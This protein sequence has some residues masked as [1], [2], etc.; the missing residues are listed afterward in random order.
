VVRAFQQ[1]VLENAPALPDDAAPATIAPAV[2]V[3]ALL[4]ARFDPGAP[5]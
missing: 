2:D 3:R 1:V 4:R 5:R